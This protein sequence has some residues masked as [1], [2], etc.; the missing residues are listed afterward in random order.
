ME[1][2]SAEVSLRALSFVAEL[3]KAGSS[4]AVA[5]LEEC[6]VTEVCGR[7]IARACHL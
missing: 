5:R 2:D 4:E 6:G 3:I 1:S 7:V